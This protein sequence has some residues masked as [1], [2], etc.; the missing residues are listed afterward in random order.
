MWSP[1]TELGSCDWVACLQ[2][3]LPPPSSHLQVSGWSGTP[4]PFGQTVQFVCQRGYHFK[5]DREPYIVVNSGLFQS[6]DDYHQTHVTFTCQDGL[7]EGM[8]DLRGFFD[9]PSSEEEWPRCLL[10]KLQP[11]LEVLSVA[12]LIF[13]SP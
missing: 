9:V 13:R 1:G 5:V 8:E 12:L 11:P 10:G 2:P 3:P 4:I 7:A 6:Q